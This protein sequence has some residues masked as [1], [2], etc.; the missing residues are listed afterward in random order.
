MREVVSLSLGVLGLACACGVRGV[1]A[2]DA[3]VAVRQYVVAHRGQLEQDIERGSGEALYQLSLLADCQNLAELG[4]TLHRKHTEIFPVPPPRDPDVADRIVVLMR[5]R[6]EFGCRDLE[7]G[8][9]RP[10]S[11]GRR[12]VYGSAERGGRPRLGE[13]SAWARGEPSA[14]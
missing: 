3:T 11:A 13:L 10:L 5:E 2:G 12:R 1:P 14:R 9:S 4:R 7:L 6:P 8:R